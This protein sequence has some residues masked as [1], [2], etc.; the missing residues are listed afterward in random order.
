MANGGLLGWRRPPLAWLAYATIL[1]GTA[2]ATEPRT[3]DAPTRAERTALRIVPQAA[4]AKPAGAMEIVVDRADDGARQAGHL[5]LRQALDQAIAD[6]QDN[7]IRIGVAP[8]TRGDV[9]IRLDRPLMLTAPDDAG[10]DTLLADSRRAT[11]TVAN[12]AQ[13][14]LFA[15]NARLHLKGVALAGGRRHALALTDCDGV[16]LEDCAITGSAGAGIALFRGG[17]LDVRGGRIASNETHGVEAHGAWQVELSRT[18]LDANRQAALAVFDDGEATLATCTMSGAGR[19]GI[20]AVDRAR[21]RASE[22]DAAGAA[23]ALADVS[24]SACVT[25]ESSELHGGAKFGA[26]VA[27]DGRLTMRA[28]TLTRNSGRGLEVQGSAVVTLDDTTVERSGEFGI[29]LFGRA[30]LSARGGAISHNGGHGVAVRDHA[31]A[32]V[33]DCAFEQNEFSGAGAP[34]GLDGGRLSLSRCTFHGNGMRPVF[35]GP[36]HIDPP[37]PI[38]ERIDG[39]IVTVRCAPRS[40]VDLYSDRVGEATTFLRTMIADEHGRIR[41]DTTTVPAGEVIAAAATTVDGHT[42][43]FN[44]VAARP[45]R[46]VLAALLARTGPYADDAGPVASSS[47]LHRWRPGTRVVF[48]F[49]HRPP[50]HI[51]QYLRE[52]VASIRGWVGGTID[53]DVRFGPG[54][55]TPKGVVIVPIRYVSYDDRDL[56]GAGGMTFTRWDALGYFTDPVRI[57]LSRPRPGSSMQACPRVAVHEIMHA[58]GLFHGRVGLLSRMQG[59]ATPPDGYVNDFSAAPTYF[60]VAALQRLYD[61]RVSGGATLE[62]LARLGLIPRADGSEIARA[63]AEARDGS[64]AAAGASGRPVFSPQPANRR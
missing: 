47:G 34:D 52:F 62:S 36:L 30:K 40:T 58:L 13:A 60:D 49:D 44:V 20:A 18:T 61:P 2:V 15:R 17:R 1:V 6:P 27:D 45:D 38:V 19:W 53:V 32:D 28:C 8:D 11:I 46:H 56:D 42:S 43:E 5:T 64:A 9:R 35:R 41:I 48:A 29:V 50:P 63:D 25:L 21:V 4:L 26:I 37:V 33:V 31:E 16:V 12:D 23:F 59:Q 10:T 3:A 7:T 22:L 14:V 57:V 51:E 24:G 54:G 55:E 39:D